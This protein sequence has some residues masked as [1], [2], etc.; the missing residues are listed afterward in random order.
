[1]NERV[2][3]TSALVLIDKLKPHPAN[4]R[5]GNIDM[6]QESLLAHGQYRPIVA[7]TSTGHI[8]AGNHTW[9][10]AKALGWA[11]VAVT[12]LDVDDLTAQRV[13]IADNR[14][15]DLATYD[16]DTLILLLRSLPTLDA[17]GF[18]RYDLD[19]LENVFAGGSSEGGALTE[20]PIKSDIRV[21]A[22]EM[23]IEPEVLITWEPTVTQESKTATIK[24]LRSLLG[25][26]PP[27]PKVHV[28]R[29][30][31]Q[32]IHTDA[33]LVDINSVEPFDINARQGDIGAISESLKH[34][35][36]YRPIVVNQPTNQILVG[37]H[38]WRAAKHLGWKQIAVNYVNY[39]EETALR[40]VLMDNRSADVSTYDDTALLAVLKQIPLAGTG[41]NN[42]DLDELLTD[43]STGRANRN[44]AKTSDI[45]CRVLKWS[46][47]VDRQTYD[48]WDNQPDQYTFI[49]QK[50]NLPTNSWT[51]EAP[52]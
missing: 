33:D 44:P 21:G 30:A 19:A 23:W 27:A 36:Q 14:T 40:V 50:L 18:D 10:A 3:V 31:D 6:I 13:L 11:S 26:P 43:V 16:N 52:Q 38:T 5:R 12:W 29:V 15:S 37:N 4:P 34:L 8:L 48:E 35:G 42:D 47:K 32:T 49:T 20:P 22:Y 25:F 28:K 45:K 9:K 46:W 1:M 17:T 51:T 39:D 41:F 2:P 7:Q 24:H